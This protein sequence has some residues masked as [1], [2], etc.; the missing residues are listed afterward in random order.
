MLEQGANQ[1]LE[2]AFGGRGDLEPIANA[3]YPHA[4]CGDGSAYKVER[5]Q[6]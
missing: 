6:I 2:R 5:V 1:C 4:R 3:L